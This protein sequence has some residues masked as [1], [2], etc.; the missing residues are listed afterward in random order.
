MNN[1]LAVKKNLPVLHIPFGSHLPDNAQWE[2]R[3]E[4]HS[5]SSD[6]VYIVAQNKQKRHFGCSCPGYRRHRNC[7]HLQALQLPCYEQ[8]HEVLLG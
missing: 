4:I 3:F 6:R 1:S 5:S 2:K 7:K 8:P